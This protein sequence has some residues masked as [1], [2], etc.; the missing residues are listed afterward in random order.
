MS[1]LP[2]KM[3]PNFFYVRVFTL[4]LSITIVH[5]HY[6]LNMIYMCLFGMLLEVMEPYRINDVQAAAYGAQ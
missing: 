6:L 2:G 3:E 4:I 1:E 5:G